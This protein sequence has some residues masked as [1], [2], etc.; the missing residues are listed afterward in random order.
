MKKI[1]LCSILIP[2]VVTVFAQKETFDIVSYTAPAGWTKE[3]T[4]TIITYTTGN[5]KT[6]TWCQLSIVKSTNSKGNI[7]ADFNSEWQNLIVKNYKITEAPTPNEVQQTE[8]WKIKAGAGNF[9]FNNKTAMAL[10]TT[11]SGYDRCASIVATTNSQEYTKDIEALLGSVD[12]KKPEPTQQTTAAIE[13]KTTLVGTWGANA[14][15]NSDY[16]MKN[17]IMNSLKRQYTF[18]GDGTYQFITKAFDPLMNNIILGKESGIYQING[19]TVTVSPVRSVLESWSKKN[20]TDKWGKLLN[21]EN[22]P[23]EKV[24]YSFTKHYFSGI[25][26]WSLVLIADKPTNRDG[27]FCNN[28]SFENAWYYNPISPNNP[29]IDLPNGE[30]VI[31]TEIKKNPAQKTIPS[32]NTAIAGTWGVGTTVAS[33]INMNINEGSMVT[34]Y[35]FNAGGTYSFHVKTFR[36][37]L[38]KLLLTKESG[39]YQVEGNNLI[40]NP[41]RSVVESWSRKNGTDNWGKLLSSQKQDLE[42]TT[43]QFS[44]EDFG[45]GIVLVLK[46]NKVTKR[47]GAFNNSTKDAWF[48]PAKSK[49]EE[50]KLP[51]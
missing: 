33:G 31:N 34:Q 39:T 4:A 36:Y 21:T 27:P 35:I 23:L 9:I 42:K 45:S 40:V 41:Q 51:N 26:I 38:D 6:G 47:D 5:E 48:Y 10:L 44:T 24:T 8:G 43:Y 17:A 2:F 15:D 13:D 32:T 22:I 49:I 18:R 14:G 46:A 29:V 12:L 20:G 7:E 1:F 3:V 30:Q 37:Q 50:I 11:A 25:Q 28:K 19:T 16:R